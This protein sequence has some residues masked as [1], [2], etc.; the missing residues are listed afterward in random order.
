M[1]LGKFIKMQAKFFLG[2]PDKKL[3]PNAR[4]HWATLSKA[5][6]KAKQD[7]YY[8]ALEAGLGKLDAD[9]LDVKLTFYPPSRRRYDADN[10][11]ASHKAALDGISMATGID[12]SKFQITFGMAGAIEK[13]GLVKVELDW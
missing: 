4:V 2:W 1:R 7:A 3:S 11:L 13:H 9:R 12:D 6:K 10:L 8:L 5:K